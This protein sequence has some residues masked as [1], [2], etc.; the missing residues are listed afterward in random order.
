VIDADGAWRNEQKAPACSPDALFGERS[1]ETVTSIFCTP[2]KGGVAY[3][4][5]A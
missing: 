5:N 4:R 2:Q 1:A 3:Q